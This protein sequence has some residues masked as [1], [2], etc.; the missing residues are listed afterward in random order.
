VDPLAGSYYVEYLTD[1]IEARSQEYIDQIDR[2]GGAVA[3]IEKGFIQKEIAAS[4]YRFQQE[5]EK[6]QRI[7]VGQ[8]KFQ[9]AE[10]K[11]PDLLKVDPAVGEKQV[12]RL[13]ELKSTRDNS[14]VAQALAE[15]KTA[16]QGA[17]NL[18]YPITKAVK[19]LATLGEICD[20]LR[21]VFG[22]YEAPALV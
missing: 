2:M 18:M 11:L 1:Q 5:V 19:A 21:E 9:V 20:T 8:N 12:A 14:A 10:E 16:A 7:I 3:A 17:D 13:K 6:G 4:A 15:L 22:E